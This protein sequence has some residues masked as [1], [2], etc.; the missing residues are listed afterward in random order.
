MFPPSVPLTPVFL[1]AETHF[2]FFPFFPSLLFKKEPEVVFDL[3]YRCGPGKDLPLILIVN[4]IHRF[5]AEI[6]EAVVSVSQKGMPPLAFAFSDPSSGLI[7]H[8]F[9]SQSRVYRFVIKRDKLP[10]GK[11]LV[12][13]KAVITNGKRRWTVVNDNFATTSK[14]PFS[15]FVSNETL[16]GTDTCSF[17]DLHVH[18]QYS[19]SHVEFGPPISVINEV[20]DACGL[21]FLSITDHSYDLCCSMTDYQETDRDLARWKSST[22]EITRSD[23]FKTIVIQ[24]EEISAFNFRRKAVHLCAIGISDYISGSV[25]GARARK[26]PTMELTDAI[27][28]VHNQRGIAVAAHPGSRFGIAQRLF[29]HRGNWSQADMGNG[30]DAVQAVNNGFGNSWL[31][32]RKLWTNELLKGRRL[33]L[34]AGNDSHGD[35]NRYRYVS[36]PFFDISENFSRHLS[37]TRT[38][39]YRKAASREEI[40]AAIRNGETFVTSG[41][42]L[43]IKP[44]QSGDDPMTIPQ[45]CQSIIIEST[46]T[47]EFGGLCYLH[48][49]AGITGEKTERIVFAKSYKG[50]KKAIEEVR[51][52][53]I[54]R[55]GYIRAEAVCKKD[56][57]SLTFAATSPL[58]FVA[59]PKEP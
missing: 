45:K 40:L 54:T 37:Y 34:V 33:P 58:Y 26:L 52:P 53:P 10:A 7:R 1:Y 23:G 32:A 43:R 8:P 51:L 5:P 20:S 42:F 56:D 14:L 57:C 55:K 22:A 15:C 6:T 38:G 2:R 41:P 28:Q 31:R 59:D 36:V 3:P 44:S 35:F 49:F 16:P 21:D 46:S 50:E 13:C 11:I 39:I 9:D 12:N 4:D 17:G 48:V 29:L 19:Q 24:G 25:D 27:R 18:S 30:L 47:C